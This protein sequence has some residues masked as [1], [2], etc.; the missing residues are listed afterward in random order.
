MI[1]ILGR[2]ALG[3][4]RLDVSLKLDYTL[5]PGECSFKFRLYQS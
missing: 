1:R 5:T 2:E 3:E 4:K